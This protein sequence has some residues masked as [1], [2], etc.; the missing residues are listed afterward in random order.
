MYAASMFL[1]SDP[2]HPRPR[3]VVRLGDNQILQGPREEEGRERGDRGRSEKANASH[4]YHA[5]GGETLQA[6]RLSKQKL[7]PVRFLRHRARF[8]RLGQGYRESHNAPRE[9]MGECPS[10]INMRTTTTWENV[11]DSY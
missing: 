5:E 7:E 9:R 6:G 1:L 8:D 11:T 2:V 10:S 4:V 3:E